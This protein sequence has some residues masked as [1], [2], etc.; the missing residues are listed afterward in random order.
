MPEPDALLAELKRLDAAMTPGDWYNDGQYVRHLRSREVLAYATLSGNRAGIARLRT[1]LPAVIARLERAARVEA[2][3]REMV[4]HEHWIVWP[5]NVGAGKIRD[6]H[7]RAVGLAVE[8]AR[9]ALAPET[10]TALA[11]RMG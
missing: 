4:S 11:R 1:L 6:G 3:A 5:N 10:L 2:A 8:Q 7:G 9:A